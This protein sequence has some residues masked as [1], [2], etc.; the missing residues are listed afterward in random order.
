MNSFRLYVVISII[1]CLRLLICSV[2]PFSFIYIVPNLVCITMIIIIII[3]IIITIIIIILYREDFAQQY[4]KCEAP[5]G[6]PQIEPLFVRR[7]S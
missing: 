7:F 6:S 1:M 5:S 4:D 3:I 2:L